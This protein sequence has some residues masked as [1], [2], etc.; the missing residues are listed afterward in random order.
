MK[1]TRDISRIKKGEVWKTYCG[2][3]IEIIAIYSGRWKILGRPLHDT[4]NFE[5][6]VRNTWNDWGCHDGYYSSDKDLDKKI[7]RNKNPEYYL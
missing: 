5:K 6:G 4:K 2:T 3:A 1:T 7:D